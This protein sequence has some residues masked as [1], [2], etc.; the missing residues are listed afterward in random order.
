[1]KLRGDA[2][3]RLIEYSE[4]DAAFNMAVDEALSLM[5]ET[6]DSP[7]TLRFY[8][9]SAPS[10]TIGAFQRIGDINADAC[11]RLAIP[12]VRRPTGGRA[13]LHGDE[14]TFSF[15][16]GTQTPPFS[17][18]SL[19]HN[20]KAIG[21]AFFLAFRRLG[22][23]CEITQRRLKRVEV[24]P[25]ASNPMCFSAASYS[26]ITIVGRKILGAAQKR[27]KYALLEQ[28]SIPLSVDRTLM[29]AV[30]N[31]A[32][33]ET[34]AAGLREFDDSITLASVQSAVTGAFEDVFSVR[35]LPCPL[36]DEEMSLARK[37]IE[38]YLSRQWTYRK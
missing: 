28:G 1:M 29:S 20:Y 27:Y 26:E 32:T 35:L 16:T 36:A 25:M 4:N 38:K 24:G 3:W 5:I 9:W 34:D 10:V 15:S 13:I 17:V 11:R 33:S 23:N 22:L 12:I 2:V 30:F 7:P 37:L 21:E 31:A 19:L 14:L 18:T 6:G 8:G